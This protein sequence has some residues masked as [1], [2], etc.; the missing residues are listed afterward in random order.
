MDSM[1]Q[2][3]TGPEQEAKG[4]P[5][6][7]TSVGVAS[8]IFG[9]VVFAIGLISTYITINS[10]PTGSMFSPVYLIG[11]LSCLIG[12]FGGM[13]AIWHYVGEYDLNV[14][15]GKG[16]LIG[17]FTGVGIAVVSA[18][19]GQI[20]NLI[21]PDMTQKMIESTIANIEAMDLPEQQKQ[22]IIDS[23]AESMEGQYSLGSQLLWG[24]PM[25]G[26]LNLLTGMIGAKVFGKEEEK[27]F[28]QADGEMDFER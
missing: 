23:T 21:D 28:R 13:V 6:Y 1:E 11:I 8:V 3:N 7:W 17:F 4:A 18:V 20:W 22:Q 14:K 19:F 12:A 27:G 16:A 9:I 24:I 5:S 15:L 10:E 2:Q 25:F 26:I